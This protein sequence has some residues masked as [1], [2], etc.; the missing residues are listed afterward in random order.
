M[1]VLLC[2]STP[3][4]PPGGDEAQAQPREVFE[5]PEPAQGREG[6]PAFH[7]PTLTTTFLAPRT[8]SSPHPLTPGWRD[9]LGHDAELAL[10]RKTRARGPRGG[11]EKS[12]CPR[13][14]TPPPPPL[15]RGLILPA[16]TP[17]LIHVISLSQILKV[18]REKVK[19]LRKTQD[20]D[21]VSLE[22]LPT[23]PTNE[24]LLVGRIVGKYQLEQEAETNKNLGVRSQH[25]MPALAGNAAPTSHLTRPL[26]SRRWIRRS[27]P[28]WLATDCKCSPNWMSWTMGLPPS[29][30]RPSSPCCRCC[31]PWTAP[32]PCSSRLRKK[33]SKTPPCS[34]ESK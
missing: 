20:N 12:S 24:R 13:T 5:V 16:L 21:D 30:R 28:T 25:V 3:P 31:R 8:P 4:P 23:P 2:A 18:I 33:L 6:V 14:P 17:Q 26:S 9:P 34:R 29:S 15:L 19:D 22:R 11:G 7:H 27:T 32:R 10:D 1:S